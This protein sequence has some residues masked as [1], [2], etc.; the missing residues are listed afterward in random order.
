M[1]IEKGA[2]AGH[3][4]TAAAQR[5]GGGAKAAAQAAGGGDFLAMMAA[6]EDGL[7]LAEG[8]GAALLPG[9]A[10]AEGR[11][12]RRDAQA[13]PA[14]AQPADAAALAALLPAPA[15]PVPAQPVPASPAAEGSATRLAVQP[16]GGK[17]AGSG[18]RPGAQAAGPVDGQAAPAAAAATDPRLAPQYASV[19]EQLQQHLAAREQAAPESALRQA[20]P[21]AAVAGQA[22]EMREPAR[23]ERGAVQALAGPARA[24][25]QVLVPEPAGLAGGARRGGQESAGDGAGQHG[26][27]HGAAGWAAPDFTPT[28]QYDAALAGLDASAPPDTAFDRQLADQLRHW[29][30]QGV[31]SA[32][33]T[34]G[35]S[36]P[37]QVRI[38][39]DGNEAQVQF[40]AEHAATRDMLAGSVDQLRDLLGAQGL[41]LSGVSVGAHGGQD[42]R[43]Q[44]GPDAGAAAARRPAVQ[45]APATE[46]VAAAPRRPT[47]ALDLYV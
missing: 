26:N 11:R 32:E 2:A 34:V 19:F 44:A 28:V 36:E 12:G 17:P 9:G 18:E 40:R 25:V 14:D 5:T 35:T 27:S 37:V 22:R 29:A 45:A 10:Q 16:E 24:E 1:G 30:S 38:A 8:D 7:G 3:A 20:A 46:T 47:G 33:L 21:A 6:L 4:G 41:V 13:L 39:L 15:T 31:R 23:A 43:G 42:G